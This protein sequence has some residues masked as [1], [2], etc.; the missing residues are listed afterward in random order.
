[1]D[2]TGLNVNKK[3]GERGGVS[4]DENLDKT[5]KGEGLRGRRGE[6]KEKKPKHELALCGSN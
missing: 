2:G 3:G 4:K 5:I 6:R 1:L